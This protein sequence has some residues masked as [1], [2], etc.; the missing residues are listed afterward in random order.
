MLKGADLV[1]L[2]TNWPPGA[3]Q[4]A[5]FVINARASENKIYF[6]AAS[7][8]GSERGFDFIGKSK[9]CDVLGNSVEFAD[10]RQ[11]TVIVA[12]IDLELAR[13]KRI[14]RVPGK[15]SIDRRRDRRPD[16]YGALV[17]AD[18]SSDLDNR[19]P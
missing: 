3:E 16:L 1:V 13:N 18:P 15:H 5:D 11:E 7:R 6:A 9:I 8:V 12:D 10:H 19:A 17:A 2:P 4:T 14:E